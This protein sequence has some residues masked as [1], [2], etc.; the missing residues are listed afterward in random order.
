MD[1]DTPVSSPPEKSSIS[2]NSS[3]VTSHKNENDTSSNDEKE[4]PETIIQIH[5]LVIVGMSDHY[6]RVMMD[7]LNDQVAGSPSSGN[8]NEEDGGS[9]ATNSNNNSISSSTNKECKD[10]LMGL[11]FG[12]INEDSSISVVDVEEI[13]VDNDNN[14]DHFIASI[15]TKIDL[16]KKVFP[17]HLVVGWY[18]LGDEHLETD[19]HMSLY[20]WIQTFQTNPLFVWMDTSKPSN[21]AKEKQEQEEEDDLL[22][23]NLYNI[24]NNSAFVQLELN[25]KTF[26]PERIAMDA[27]VLSTQKPP[28]HQ[29]QQQASDGN[30]NNNKN[31]NDND[32]KN[33]NN[34]NNTATSS[35]NP[36][37]EVTM[38][39][40]EYQLQSIQ[41]SMEAMNS[42]IAVLLEFLRKTQANEIPTDYKLL[43]EVNALIQQL[44]FVMNHNDVPNTKTAATT[45]TDDRMCNNDTA[46]SHLDMEY[47]DMMILTYLATIAK[48]TK[49]VQQYSDKYL[50]VISST[51]I[52]PKSQWATHHITTSSG[53]GNKV[54]SSTTPYGF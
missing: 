28:T 39:T 45:V 5:P 4:E 12:I 34:N 24:H 16:H 22:P 44:T 50:K 2:I 40:A 51:S 29:T 15:Q 26:E 3:M 27:V 30:N 11:M 52:K 13:L 20:G 9:S 31:D 49:A 53:R 54:S 14:E 23:L 32:N 48:T 38:T 1:I 10:K 19:L 37:K 18:R 25:L 42:R 8:G 17:Q 36:N 21:T 47:N 43:R 6:T 41:S 46:S 33:D 35:S 7:H